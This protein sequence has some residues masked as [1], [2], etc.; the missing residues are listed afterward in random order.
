METESHTE[1]LSAESRMRVLSNQTPSPE[2]PQ[3]L[4]QLSLTSPF[5]QVMAPSTRNEQ[6]LNSKSL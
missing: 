6:S 2:N 4:L 1:Q 5:R 3:T